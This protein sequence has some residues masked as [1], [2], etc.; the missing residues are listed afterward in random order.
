MVAEK[1]EIIIIIIIIIHF[2]APLG[3]NFRDAGGG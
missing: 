1:P 3:R 2:I